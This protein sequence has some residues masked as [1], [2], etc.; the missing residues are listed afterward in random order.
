MS[1]GP[2]LS[3][4]E[5][6][7]VAAAAVK[8]T[9][10]VEKPAPIATPVFDPEKLAV[11]TYGDAGLGFI[12]GMNY[13]TSNGNFVRELPER[14]WYLTTPEMERNNKIARAKQRAR[15]MRGTVPH[16][17]AV[18]PD[19]VIVAAGESMQILRAEAL[20]E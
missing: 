4:A 1:R 3:K 2:W 9:Q 18:L 6:R 16:V 13:F 17:G 8:L 5:V 15:T 7:R 10:V 20:S 14:S 19:K 12:Q 11:Q